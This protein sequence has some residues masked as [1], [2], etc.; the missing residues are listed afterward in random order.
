MSRYVLSWELS[1]DMDVNFC[2]MALERALV[3]GTR[4]PAKGIF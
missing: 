4:T 2:I 1:I 3:I